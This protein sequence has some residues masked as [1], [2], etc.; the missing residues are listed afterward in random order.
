MPDLLGVV[1]C[2][3]TEVGQAFLPVLAE[4]VSTCALFEQRPNILK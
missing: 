4:P 3:R 2:M 1:L